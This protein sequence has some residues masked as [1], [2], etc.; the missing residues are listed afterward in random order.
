MILAGSFKP[1]YDRSKELRRV[2]DEIINRASI[3]G[4]EKPGYIQCAA[5]RQ[6]EIN[7]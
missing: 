6:K 7:F 2:S 5:T 4:F 3:P 1:G